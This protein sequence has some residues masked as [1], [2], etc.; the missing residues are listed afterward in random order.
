MYR[1]S[2]TKYCSVMS[3]LCTLKSQNTNYAR[4]L[5]TSN[6]NRDSRKVMRLNISV[7]IKH[8]KSLWIAISVTELQS[9]FWTIWLVGKQ[10]SCNYRG[11]GF[12]RA[13]LRNRKG[14]AAF[15]SHISMPSLVWKEIKHPIP[16]LYYTDV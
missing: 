13:I 15:S 11:K 9:C 5:P 2:Q 8:L 1:K 6:S 3:A 10:R 7:D 14:Q 12:L 4:D 16:D